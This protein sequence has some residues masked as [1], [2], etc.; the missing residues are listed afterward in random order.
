MRADL[1]DIVAK[2]EGIDPTGSEAGDLAIDTTAEVR[3]QTALPGCPDQFG[4][5]EQ[6]RKS[7]GFQR[8]GV[9]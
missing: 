5:G 1:A 7:C 6:A 8:S 2:R 9:P 4:N 3:P